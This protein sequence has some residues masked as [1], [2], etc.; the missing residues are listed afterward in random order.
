M[1][2]VT[3]QQVSQIPQYSNT[4]LLITAEYRM[5]FT[6]WDTDLE[7]ARQVRNGIIQ[8]LTTFNAYSPSGSTSPLRPNRVINVRLAPSEPQTDSITWCLM[9]D[10]MITNNETI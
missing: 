7:R 8:F 3:V 9:L 5:Q 1:P 10:A 2:S 4:S 6:I